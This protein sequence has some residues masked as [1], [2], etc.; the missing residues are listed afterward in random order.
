MTKQVTVEDLKEV[1]PP[2]QVDAVVTTV[3]ADEPCFFLA[4]ENRLSRSGKTMCRYQILKVV[5]KDRLVTAYIYLGPASRFHA[6]QFHMVGGWVDDT[7]RG[8]ACHTVGELQTGA[9]ELRSRAPRRELERMPL[10]EMFRERVDQRQRF[11]K[12]RT[13]SGYKG[14]LVRS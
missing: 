10:Q 11:A 6:D 2:K 5:R 12:R 13:T 4:E 8:Q 14:Q 3:F 7:G 1:E 9:D